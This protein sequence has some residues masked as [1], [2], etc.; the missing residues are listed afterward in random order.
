MDDEGREGSLED[1]IV[2]KG[3]SGGRDRM[4]DRRDGCRD[5]PNSLFRWLNTYQWRK[6]EEQMMRNHCTWA[7]GDTVYDNRPG[8][9]GSR[10][11]HVV[12]EPGCFLRSRFC[13]MLLVPLPPWLL[14]SSTIKNCWTLLE[15]APLVSSA[16][17]D[18]KRMVWYVQVVGLACSQA[19][20]R[21]LQ[22]FVCKE[23]KF[24]MMS[25]RDKKKR[26]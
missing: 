2:Q 17:Y 23:L 21:F 10:R 16:K 24:G 19:H 1:L 25:E 11:S 5:S 14:P 12:V 3:A 20:R 7:N 8:R 15:M 26:L 9:S 6:Q 18:R 4:E 13:S 22:I